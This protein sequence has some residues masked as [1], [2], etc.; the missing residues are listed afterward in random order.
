MT[1][2]PHHSEDLVLEPMAGAPNDCI[3]DIDISTPR[4][5]Q[6]LW[7]IDRSVVRSGR[8][9]S[10]IEPTR[11]LSLHGK[12]W[13]VETTRSNCV[14][15]SSCWRTKVA[16]AHAGQALFNDEL[17]LEIGRFQSIKTRLDAARAACLEAAANQ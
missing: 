2:Q 12:P 9:P 15:L 17:T 8:G 5:P 7:Y 14:M 1:H 13:A 16:A 11:W 3:N 10:R 6:I 4:P